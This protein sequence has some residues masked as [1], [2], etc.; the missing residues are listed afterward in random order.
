MLAEAA[1]HKFAAGQLKTISP[2]EAERFF[3]VDGYVVGAARKTK[4]ERSIA[5]FDADPLLGKAIRRVA[6]LVRRK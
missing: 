3:R 5:A 4:I 6:A 2:V 1:Y